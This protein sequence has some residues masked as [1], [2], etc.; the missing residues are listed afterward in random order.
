MNPLHATLA[1]TL[2]PSKQTPFFRN[3]VL[4]VIGTLIVAL[5]AHVN[6]PMLPVPMTLQTLAVLAIGGA[7]GA[8]LGASTMALYAAE[9]AIGLPVFT[10]TA[11]GYPGITGPTGGYILGFIAAA[12]LVGWL[13]E[14]GYDRSV[15]KMLIA[16]LAGAA[17]LYI[18][19]LLWLS[20]FT[21]AADAITYGLAPFWIGDIVKAAIA[22]LGFPAV[23]SVMGKNWSE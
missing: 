18:P 19:G 4:A 3:V 10:P 22:T 21:G 23:W 5:A 17:I 8:R 11:D 1:N 7:F 14:R 12:A 2:W 20:K 9:G 13:A 15:P 16:T 6:V